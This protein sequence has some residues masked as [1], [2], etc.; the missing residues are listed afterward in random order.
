[1]FVC[2]IMA[3]GLR[4]A[5]CLACNSSYG[6][7]ELQDRRSLIISLLQKTTKTAARCIQQVIIKHCVIPNTHTARRVVSENYC[8]G[9]AAAALLIKDEGSVCAR[10]CSCV[11]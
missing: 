3:C 2:V 11:Q 10:V 1:M 9:P 5:C 4:S 7:A 8:R 6:L